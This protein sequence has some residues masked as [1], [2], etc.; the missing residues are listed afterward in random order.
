MTWGGAWQVPRGIMVLGMLEKS[1]GHHLPVNP[2]MKWAGGKRWLFKRYRHLFPDKIGRLIDPFLGGGSAFFLLQPESA[3]L[4]DLN[5]D[6]IEMYECVRDYPRELAKRL[7]AY[8]KQHSPE[9]YYRVRSARPRKKLEKA[10]RLLY[11]NRTCW[12]GL[13]RV[14]LKGEFNVPVGTKTKIFEAPDEFVRASETLL[15]ATLSASDFADIIRKA[16][17]GDVVFADPP[18]FDTH[19]KHDRFLKYNKNLFS[20]DDQIRLCEEVLSARSRGATC[21]ITNPNN[22]ALVRM[23]RSSGVVRILKRHSVLAGAASA[24]RKNQEILIELH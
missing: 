5:P 17:K 6:L 23:Y 14:N 10:A 9:F 19:K 20:W 4:G 8:Q 3:L 21:F 18:Y 2:F 7:A 13:F 15:R 22:R 24:R 11:L 1:N 12:N 16:K